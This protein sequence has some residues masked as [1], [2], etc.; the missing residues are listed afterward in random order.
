MMLKTFR[1]FQQRKAGTKLFVVAIKN[2]NFLSA[3]IRQLIFDEYTSVYSK[4]NVSFH[5]VHLRK[6]CM[7]KLQI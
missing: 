5:E 4:N 2:D 3:R 6:I 1:F 7:S